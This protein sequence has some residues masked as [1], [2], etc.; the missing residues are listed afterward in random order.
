MKSCRSTRIDASADAVV[1]P[2]TKPSYEFYDPFY[3]NLLFFDD[4]H[5][6]GFPFGDTRAIV[7]MD[8]THGWAC[9]LASFFSYD[10]P[11]AGRF[12]GWAS[13]GYLSMDDR[14]TSIHVVKACELRVVGHSMPS[15]LGIYHA[16]T[17]TTSLVILLS[18]TQ[19]AFVAN[20]R[21]PPR[22][23]LI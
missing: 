16:E 14:L 13:A 8:E 6:T 21:S 22:I 4:S 18:S 20:H 12:S 19:R 2:R 15:L 17:T 10:T 1:A 9:A 23:P 11:T 7:K 3:R 5:Q